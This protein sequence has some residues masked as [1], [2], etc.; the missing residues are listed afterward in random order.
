[1]ENPH[2]L[3]GKFLLFVL[4]ALIAPQVMAQSLSSKYPVILTEKPY[5]QENETVGI[6]GENFSSFERVRLNVR[7]LD[8]NLKEEI[9]LRQWDTYT[10]VDGRFNTSW[11]IFNVYPEGGRFIIEAEGSATRTIS[12]TEFSTL[13]PEAASVSM[14]QCANSNA[15]PQ[16][17]ECPDNGNTGWVTG[18]VGSNRSLYFEGD[19][20]AYRNIL[21]G[22]T[23][24]TD[25]KWTIEY[26]TTKG[27]INAIDYMTT[28]NETITNANPCLSGANPSAFC[29]AGA[30]DSTS[31]IQIDP[32]VTNGRDGMNGTSDDIVQ[33]P[34]VISAWGGTITA[35][36]APVYTGTF[37]NGATAASVDL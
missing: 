28:Y 7:F 18:L 6:R 5:Y 33:I 32:N 30:P 1:M 10:D 3:R 35:V 27:S 25:Y 16:T 19:T 2:I 11:K 31:A 37:P 23:P 15:N 21:A 14:S 29:T 34:G 13:A 4:F 12:K 8:Q 36:S 9:L 17:L 26:D 22:L 20:I 24:G